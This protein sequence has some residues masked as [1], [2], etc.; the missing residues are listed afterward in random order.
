M[1]NETKSPSQATPVVAA[2]ELS[3]ERALFLVEYPNAQWPD[4]ARYPIQPWAIDKWQGWKA[5]AVLAAATPAA[6]V[7]AMWQALEK[8][9]STWD[10][11]KWD[12]G[13]DVGATIR[14]DFRMYAKEYAAARNQT[15][16]KD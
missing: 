3:D 15:N 10:G 11:V 12:E 1:T 7:T 8:L 2:S 16:T 9:A 5:R 14:H 4:D 13:D 6:S